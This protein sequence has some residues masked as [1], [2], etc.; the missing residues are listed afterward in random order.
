MPPLPAHAPAHTIPVDL[1]S[2]LTVLTAAETRL[3]ELA[4]E[5]T[6]TIDRRAL[7]REY[8]AVMEAT[9]RIRAQIREG[10]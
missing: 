6:K 5:T 2:L 9:T 7:M 10:F 8:D 1:S 3:S 4:L